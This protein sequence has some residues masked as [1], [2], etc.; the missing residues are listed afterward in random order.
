MN[1]LLEKENSTISLAFIMQSYFKVPDDVRLNTIHFFIL[2]IA[3]LLMLLLHQ[4]I[5]NVSE[6]IF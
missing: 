2:K 4:I 5:L 1:Y 6:R 3:K